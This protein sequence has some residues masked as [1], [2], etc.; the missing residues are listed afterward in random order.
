LGAT[1]SR[2]WNVSISDNSAVS[3]GGLVNVGTIT[4]LANST[5][6]ANTASGGGGLFNVGTITSAYDLTFSANDAAEFGGGIDNSGTIA[7]LRVSTLS[8]DTAGGVGGGEISNDGSLDVAG[9]IFAAGASGGDCSGTITDSGFNLGS[10][11]SCPFTATTSNPSSTVKGFLAPLADNGGP[12]KTVA[13]LPGANPA[14]GGI[15]SPP[16]CSSVD[17]GYNFDQRG[18]PRPDT[19]DIGA[20]QTMPTTTVVSASATSVASGTKINLYATVTPATTVDGSAPGEA[21][22]F[23]NGGTS[24]IGMGAMRGGNPN[25]AIFT[26]ALPAGTNVITAKYLGGPGFAASTS[27]NS[28]TVNVQ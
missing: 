4:T 3:G 18:V 25:L 2:L 14:I 9:S 20:F 5:F 15:T 23:L 10:D 11:G 26:V 16:G 19:C 7:S 21:A 24:P 6:S 1:I 12:T 27:S 8:G 17:A 22:F 28:V 13:L